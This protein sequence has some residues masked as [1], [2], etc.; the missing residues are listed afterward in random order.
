[1]ASFA[2]TTFDRAEGESVD[3]AGALRVVIRLTGSTDDG[4]IVDWHANVDHGSGTGE[5]TGNDYVLTGA[6]TGTAAIPPGQPVRTAFFEPTFTL[7]PPGPP[8]HPPSPCRF[9]VAVSFDE[10]G[11]VANVDAHLADAAPPTTD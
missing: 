4:W 3:V 9:L 11:H 8:T 7:L 1:M 10:A 5:T 6:E 2:G